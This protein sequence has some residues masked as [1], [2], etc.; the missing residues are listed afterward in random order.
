MRKTKITLHDLRFARFHVLGVK[1]CALHALHAARALY[2]ESNVDFS[3]QAWQN[4]LR[5]RP[6][7]IVF[8]LLQ[9]ASSNRPF[10]D[11]GMPF[12]I[13]NIAEI[14]YETRIHL[15]RRKAKISQLV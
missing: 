5:L 7:K 4:V 8:I 10:S 15:E 13:Y 2:I 1:A 12:S 11:S 14:P 6:P 3:D 9:I